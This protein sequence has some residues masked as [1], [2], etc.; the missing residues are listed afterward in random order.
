MLPGRSACFP[1]LRPAERGIRQSLCA[2]ASYQ[3]PA[4]SASELEGVTHSPGW[5]RMPWPLAAALHASRARCAKRF[6]ISTARLAFPCSQGKPYGNSADLSAGGPPGRTLALENE[7]HGGD[8]KTMWNTPS[9]TFSKVCPQISSSM[10][11]PCCDRHRSTS[12][13]HH[14]ELVCSA[15]AA[16]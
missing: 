13:M 8:A 7:E 15:K 1:F 14:N 6:A 9:L 10:R 2:S 4:A 3:G 11:L 12:V 16:N 5:S